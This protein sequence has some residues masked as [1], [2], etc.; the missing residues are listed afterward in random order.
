MTAMNLIVQ[1]R[2]R[3]AFLITDTAGFDGQG[4]IISFQPKVIGL[5]LADGFA[6]ISTSG[7]WRVNSL[8]LS[9]LKR[10]RPRK[11]EELVAGL[12]GLVIDADYQI[13][14]VHRDEKTSIAAVIATY[15]E[16]TDRSQGFIIGNDNAVFELGKYRPFTLQPA[17]KHLTRYAGEPIGHDIDV[18]RPMHWNPERDGAALLKA[19]RLDL[20]G[21][22][23]SE[24]AVIGGQGLLTSVSAA[25]IEH[26]VIKVWPDSVGRPIDTTPGRALDLDARVAVWLLKMLRRPPLLDFTRR[27]LVNVRRCLPRTYSAPS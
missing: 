11:I 15:A 10:L 4:N 24:Y 3:A 16:A 1:D 23:G 9:G 2:A 21:Q 5:R 20:S 13:R 18:T 6:A 14:H 17:R 8:I 22:P 26:T 19:Q 25:G 12:P 27:K 7:T